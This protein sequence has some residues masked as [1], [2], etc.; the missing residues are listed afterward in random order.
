MTTYTRDRYAHRSAEDKAE[1][2]R[3]MRG[4]KTE[5]GKDNVLHNER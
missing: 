2:D 5:K 1:H 3:F 4:E